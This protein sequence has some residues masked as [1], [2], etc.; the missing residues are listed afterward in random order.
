[1]A[2]ICSVLNSWAFVLDTN[3][4]YL[5]NLLISCFKVKNICISCQLCSCNSASL[6]D[7]SSWLQN[8]IQFKLFLLWFLHVRSKFLI[9]HWI[10]VINKLVHNSYFSIALSH[11]SLH[12][13]QYSLQLKFQLLL[14]EGNFYHT[15][16]S[17]YVVRS[18]IWYKWH[19]IV[20]CITYVWFFIAFSIL[21]QLHISFIKLC[22]KLLS[23]H[24]QCSTYVFQKH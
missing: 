19:Q 6:I 4:F 11:G 13:Y 2:L 7:R 18:A 24:N 5:E 14:V 22:S 15:S 1:M 20:Q 8:K 3:A 10:V 17:Q 9:M 23:I 21:F 16:A 12:Q